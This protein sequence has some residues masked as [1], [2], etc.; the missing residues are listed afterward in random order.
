MTQKFSFF[1]SSHKF[2]RLEAEPA[3]NQADELINFQ[4][5]FFF[6]RYGGQREQWQQENDLK[7]IQ[8]GK[9]TFFYEN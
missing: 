7:K 8:R 4:R 5:P 6:L 2:L 3:Q 9:L 1:P